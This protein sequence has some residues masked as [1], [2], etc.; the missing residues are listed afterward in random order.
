MRLVREESDRFVVSRRAWFDAAVLERERDTIF[1]QAWL[2]LGH[3]SEIPEPGDY[4][5]RR[6]GFDPVIL[7]RGEDGEV[8]VVANTCRHRGVKLCRS[9]RGNS[10][11]FRC[12]Y[13]GWTYS[14]AGELT[15]V[16][17]VLDLFGRDFDKSHFPL[18]QPAQVD[19]VYGLIFAT[20]DPDAPTLEQYLGPALW[21]LGSIFGA[22]DDGVEVLGFPARTI[23]GTNWKPESENVGGDGYHTPITHQSAFALGMFAGPQD[24]EKMGKVTG[25]TYT[26]RVVDATNGHTFRV[27]HLPVENELPTFFGLPENLWPEM[28]RNL[29]RGQTDVQDRLS[30]IH[31]NVFPNMTL[32]NN[33]KISTEARGSACRYFR[34]TTQ[35]PISPDRNEMLWWCFVPKATD[36]A[37]RQ[38]SQRA[39]LRTSGPAGLFQIDDNENFTGFADAHS[40]TVLLDENV[41]L[42]GVNNSTVNTDLG[43]PGTVYDADKSEETIRA[44][45]R[46]W[47]EYVDGVGEAVLPPFEPAPAEVAR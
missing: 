43:W 2:F 33:Y 47:S 39:Y 10:S 11:H 34:V 35:H 42:E 7:V 17:N 19:S 41:E 12:P 13:H 3:E 29:D 5:T 32:L 20:W 1:R 15:G 18:Y 38:Q 24:L 4:V 22:F 25:K 27:H 44:F 6:L 21:Y 36:H 40:G 16:T 8:N 23:V 26:G 37:W 46:R 28:S 31:G 45:W 30:L 14:S 9:D